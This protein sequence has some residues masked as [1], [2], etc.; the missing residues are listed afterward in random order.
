MIAQ[1]D[2][3]IILGTYFSKRDTLTSTEWERLSI[4]QIK[5]CVNGGKY[6]EASMV[7]VDY[8]G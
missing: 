6:E 5:E 1:I 4:L 3:I 7:V 2:V 8:N